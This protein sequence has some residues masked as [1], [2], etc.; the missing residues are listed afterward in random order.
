M[1]LAIPESPLGIDIPGASFDFEV[2]IA[3]APIGRLAV[4]VLPGGKIGAIE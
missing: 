3:D 2:T 1:Q 4:T